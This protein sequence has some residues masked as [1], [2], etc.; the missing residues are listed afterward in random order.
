[1]ANQT[2]R[3]RRCHDPE[4][5]APPPQ[6]GPGR[7]HGDAEDGV[8]EDQNEQ[9]Q[10]SG[11]WDC[12]GPHL[13]WL[14][15]EA[16]NGG[17]DAGHPPQPR[18]AVRPGRGPHP[19]TST[20]APS[21]SAPSS[22]CRGRPRSSRPGAPPTTTTSARS[23]SAPSRSQHRRARAGGPLPP[24]LGGRHPGRA[25]ATRRRAHRVGVLVGAS[26]TR[27][28]SRSTPRTLTASSSRSAGSCRRRCSPT[29]SSRREAAGRCP[30]TSPR[31]SPATAPRP[32]AAWASPSPRRRI[33]AS[34]RPAGVEGLGEDAA[35]GVED[36]AVLQGDA[37]LAHVGPE[38]AAEPLAVVGA[39]GACGAGGPCSRCS[40][41]RSAD[42]PG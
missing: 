12:G 17:V 41:L 26:T 34:A 38:A 2:Q 27:R 14:S 40:P 8:E 16:R 11:R 30:S 37:A 10:T 29:R 5:Q 18:R 15:E 6:P 31:R 28:P 4:R 24:G 13:A 20:K 3:G 36:G 23:R 22:G 35:V 21:A 42:R 1:M 33:G 19:R 39:A 7:D 9:A 32:A 25:R